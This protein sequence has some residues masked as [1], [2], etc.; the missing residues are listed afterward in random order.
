[1]LRILIAEDHLD[2]AENIGDFLT[3][4]GHQ[5]DYAYD[6]VMAVNLVE[7]QTYDAIIMDI[8][9]P[10]LD[11][12]KATRQI[13]QGSQPTVPILMLTAKDRLD[14]KLVGFDSGADDYILKPFAI[15]ELYARLVAHTRKAQ[16]DYHHVMRLNG[17]E[18]NTQNKTASFNG[19]TLQLNPT[20]FKILTLLCK[21]HPSLVNKS[22][23][24][25][26]LWRDAL[27]END[28]LRSHIYNLRKSLSGCAE[29]IKVQSKHGQGY[30][31]VFL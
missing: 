21:Q 4:K 26:Q 28:L 15:S 17:L 25:F 8:M 23:L 11:G 1:M 2:I 30:Q 12:L 27:P 18:L 5:V 9:M 7:E 22:E 31:L 13:R 24:E 10:K 19:E 29:H 20:T 6:G 16:N 14:D 3:A